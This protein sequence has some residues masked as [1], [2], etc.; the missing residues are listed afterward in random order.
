[1]SAVDDVLEGKDL[2]DLIA[3][4]P[5]PTRT[6]IELTEE[7]IEIALEMLR[8]VCKYNGETMIRHALHLSKEQFAE[9]K[10][11]RQ[12]A[13]MKLEEENTVYDAY[14]AADAQTQSDVNALLS[15]ASADEL[16]AA[17][18]AADS[19]TREQ[20]RSLLAIP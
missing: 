14:V 7:L 11:K 1:M 6:D 3:P 15:I 12:Q 10:I 18:R 2:T 17:Y 5:A 4:H 16:I 13:I 9:I 8:D 20:T 19:D